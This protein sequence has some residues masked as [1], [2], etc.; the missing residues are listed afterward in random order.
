[1]D[2]VHD[3]LDDELLTLEGAPKSVGGKFSCSFNQ[4]VSLEGAPRSVGDIFYCRHNK[5]ANLE[6]APSCF[7]IS[8]F[9]N[10]IYKW[11]SQ[12]RDITKLD[13]FIDLGIDTRDPDFMN[14]EKIYLLLE[15]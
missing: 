10:P 6:F 8:C 15:Q 13:A 12:V 3:Y 14:Q 2:K 11:W 9:N 4:L 1:M 5:L 7:N